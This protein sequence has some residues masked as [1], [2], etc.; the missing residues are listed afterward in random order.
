[1]S[2]SK[3]E[4]TTTPIHDIIN[5][6]GVAEIEQVIYA[7]SE[8][9]QAGADINGKDENG[10]TPLCLVASLGDTP[11]LRSLMSG[12]VALGGNPNTPNSDGSTAL[13]ISLLSGTAAMTGLLLQLGA[14]A[15]TLIPVSKEIA[16]SPVTALF[17]AQFYSNT[18]AESL[19]ALHTLSD[20]KA[21][22]HSPQ[23]HNQTAFQIANNIML[24]DKSVLLTS[25]ELTAP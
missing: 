15:K 4:K 6:I 11:E 16:T 1:M 24:F 22:I 20:L 9:V 5:N 2:I 10:L 25:Q 17:L 8:Q 23:Y 3:S 19:L 13:G 21:D 14:D 7:V 18:D 12:L